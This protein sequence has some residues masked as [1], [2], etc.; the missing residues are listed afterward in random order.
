VPP[1]PSDRKSSE[2]F[3]Q[4]ADQPLGNDDVTSRRAVPYG[5]R[6]P[7]AGRSQSERQPRFSGQSLSSDVAA[8]AARTVRRSPRSPDVNPEAVSQT[9]H[10]ANHHYSVHQVEQ[11]FAVQGI[12]LRNVRHAGYRKLLAFLDGRPAHAV[13]VYVSLEA[14]K[15]AFVPPIRNARKTHHGNI[16]VFW[17]PAVRSAV[18]A[19][20]RELN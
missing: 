2:D 10:S 19:A 20:L 6:R 3:P 17:R 1:A 15:C 14:C 7:G 18:H 8:R 16:A 12:R 13:Y 11:A 4:S 9:F 5:S